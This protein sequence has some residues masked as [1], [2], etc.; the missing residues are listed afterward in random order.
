MRITGALCGAFAIGGIIS[1]SKFGNVP[2]S[3]AM[4]AA[5]PVMIAAVVCFFWARL[6]TASGLSIGLATFTAIV[7]A[8][9]CG[10]AM[11]AT[12][13]STRDLIQL[14]TARGYGSAP[15][16]AL[17]Q[18]DRTAEFYA[19]GRVVYGSDGDPVRFESAL[20]VVEAMRKNNSPV[21]VFVPNEY[22]YQ[23][24]GLKGVRA[25][26]IGSNGVLAL[27]AISPG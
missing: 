1:V 13:E 11:I 17:H 2:L 22:L 4:M 19:A 15:V 25:D 9:N 8:L 27:V 21:L 12:R 26:L 16:Y 23:L 20:D 6:R 10:A 14:A 3:C 7:I 18:I 24:T 5:A